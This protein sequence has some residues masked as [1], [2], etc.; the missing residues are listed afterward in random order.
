MAVAF[1]VAVL[2]RGEWTFVAVV[3]REEWTFIAVAVAFIVVRR[4]QTFI[5]ASHGL[6]HSGH[7]IQT[8][9]DELNSARLTRRTGLFYSSWHSI[10]VF[11]IV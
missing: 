8:P 10:E 11:F 1:I 2:S 9:E 4:E 6:F 3:S 7:N 5:V